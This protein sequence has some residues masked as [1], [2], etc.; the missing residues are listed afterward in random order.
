MKF[1]HDS[2]LMESI[3]YRWYFE[4]YGVSK[5]IQRIY[6]LIDIKR[7]SDR[8]TS[9]SLIGTKLYPDRCTSIS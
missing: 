9:V 7:I 5:Q 8:R 6:L 3:S 1:K 2:L 4:R